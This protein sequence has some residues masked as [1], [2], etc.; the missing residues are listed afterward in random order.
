LKISTPQ[1]VIEKRTENWLPIVARRTRLVRAP[2]STGRRLSIVVCVVSNEC[3]T[4]RPLSRRVQ[5]VVVVDS[6]SVRRPP[7][8]R[9]PTRA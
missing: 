5:H 3:E 8:H 9:G 4:R 1:R 6:A 7:Y 2:S